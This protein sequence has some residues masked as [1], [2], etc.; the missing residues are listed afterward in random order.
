MS[1]P[2]WP[3]ISD[4]AT[5][6]L[7]GA[8]WGL[9]WTSLWGH[10]SLHWVGETHVDTATVAFGGTPYGAT[11]RRAEWARRMCTPPPGPPAELLMRPRSGVLS[12]GDA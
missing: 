5:A 3:P 2:L 8:H 12:G 10:E 11:E 9:R 6:A 7:G 1:T 4:T